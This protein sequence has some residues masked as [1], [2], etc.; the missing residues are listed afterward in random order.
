MNVKNRHCIRVLSMRQLLASRARN[1][2]AVFAIAL[3]TLL[4]TSLFTIVMSINASYE[5]YS[6]RQIGGYSHGSFKEVDEEKIA[7]LSGHPK[8]KEYGLRTVCGFTM[9]EPFAKV[10]AEISWMDANTTKW[11]YALPTTGRM[12]ES[13][14]EIAMDTTALQ[15]LGI[16][17]EPGTQVE[18]AYTV[19][20]GLDAIQER[21]D[22]FTLTGFW[23]YD[24]LMPVHYINIS[25]DYLEQVQK[26]YI[27]SGGEEF[28]TDMNVMLTSRFNIR[29][30]MEQVDTD[31]GYQWENRDAEDCVRIGVNWGYS[32]E[33]LGS[34]LDLTTVVAIFAFL[35]L[36]IFTGYLIIYNI[37]QISVSTDIRFYGLLKTIGTTPRQLRRV[38]RL[39]ALYLSVAGIPLGC[40]I[41]Y[42]VGCALTPLVIRTAIIA[43]TVKNSSSPII[44]VGAVLFSLVTVLFSCSRPG[45]MAAG[46]TPV[47]AIRYVESAPAS[48]KQRATRGAKISQMAFANL[49]RNR[50]KTVLVVL[51]LSLAVVL[52]NLVFIFTESFDSEKYISQFNAADFVVGT[53]KYFRYQ[54][55]DKAAALSEAVIEEV[56]QNTE[57]SLEG[58]A[59][60]METYPKCWVSEE[61]FREN[62][63]GYDE[64]TMNQ[65][66][67]S[68]PRRGEL[69]EYNIQI[70]G[71]DEGLLE[72]LRVY[73]G[74]LAPLY[75]AS[76]KAI[77]VGANMDD[78]GK[79]M[80]S[81]KVG[82]KLP[83]TYCEYE[84]IDSRTGEP[85]NGDTP[86]E[87]RELRAEAENEVEYTVCALVGIPFS[88][89]YRSRL[90]EGISAILTGDAL[91]QDSGQELH[92]MC[93]A[94]DTPDEAAEETAEA[95]LAD[96]S[97]GESS[98]LMYESK[99]ML[100]ADFNNFRN[101]FLIVGGVLCFIVGLVGTLNFFN[102]IL[103]GIVTRRREF[104]MLQ[105]VGMT[106]KQLK[107]MLVYE[108]V[109]YAA[110]AG[111]LSMVLALVFMPLI[112]SLLENMFWFVSF[113][114]T[115]LPVLCAALVYLVLGVTLPLAVEWLKGGKS[116]VER[117]RENE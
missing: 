29:N 42:G 107:R 33:E 10:P 8:V 36:I 82:D 25:K 85:S 1:L 16:P 86:M 57:M 20:T 40:A 106:G 31:L 65:H 112:R 110:S 79:V 94:F 104:A 74:E 52:L 61:V 77:A 55:Q 56:R 98:G 53:P 91:R 19:G 80:S 24:S 69:L 9:E 11:S 18:L 60:S 84:V 90:V 37:F 35:L 58:A 7:A 66:V 117:L 68:A 67:E 43:T 92:V 45:R 13:G 39:Q 97:A 47:E 99:A 100:R 114:F 59:Y 30:T 103:T 28:R 44:F 70:E 21:R 22:V 14:M 50:V 89:S 64:E 3:T 105:S 116:I 88:L 76:Q 4:F 72:K 41:G 63:Y 15:K 5:E 34:N 96:L 49:G 78:E 73:E 102:A 115:I 38:V 111:L 32:T 81:I 48:Q 54:G 62:T 87:F 109:F 46:V 101:M 71:M 51:S 113:R 93:Y 23:E 6:F 75:D 12:P 95:F 2:I 83:V 17:A 27:A 108:G 26:D